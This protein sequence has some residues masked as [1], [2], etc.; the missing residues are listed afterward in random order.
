MRS[1]D[2]F[3]T[4]NPH[5]PGFTVWQPARAESSSCSTAGGLV[6]YVLVAPGADAPTRQPVSARA[7]SSSTGL[8]A[9]LMGRRRWALYRSG[10][11]PA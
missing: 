6:D 10:R 9:E 11:R 7:A 4:A 8:A 3:R 5:A 2:T 1:N